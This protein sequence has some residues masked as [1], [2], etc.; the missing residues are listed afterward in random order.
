MR[1]VIERLFRAQEG[2]EVVEIKGLAF[3]TIVQLM[4]NSMF[5]DDLLDPA[6][7]AMEELEMLNGNIMVLFGKPN[8]ADYFPFLRL[9][10]LQGIRREIRKSYD[11]LH[12]LIDGII[13]I[14][15][16]RRRSSDGSDRVGDFLDVLLDY[17]EDEGPQGLTRLDIKLMITELFIGGTDS[18]T[19]T[20]EWAMTE[21]IR[22]PNILSKL[23]QE[24]SEKITN[25]KT[26]QE[27]D[28]PQLPYLTAV[29]KETMRL[30]PPSPLLLPRRAEQEVEIHGFT[31]PK[32][33][34]IWLNVLSI[35]RDPKSWDGPTCFVPE[36]FLDSDIDFRGRVFSFIPFS[37]GRRICPGMNLGL[38]MVSLILAT[39]VQKF[40][41]KLPN[42]MA[43][44]DMDMTD[45]FGLTLRKAQRLVL[46]PTKL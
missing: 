6:S 7:G 17:M 39:L 24:L 42:E 36:R 46:I 4:S 2:G 43:P 16:E 28:L 12:G 26:V 11:R 9:F 13:D 14:R 34:R 8:F 22:N 1:N 10:D 30:H 23:R 35:T 3:S 44:E 18:S 45:R 27:Q 19:T 15:T 40:D 20:V 33:T 41:W 25:G 31:I 38:R 21:L 5:S 37:S 32:N 29:I